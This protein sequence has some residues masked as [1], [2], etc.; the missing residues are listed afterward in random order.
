M[1]SEWII[2]MPLG[3]LILVGA[4][5][6]VPSPAMGQNADSVQLQGFSA[7]HPEARPLELIEVTLG[8]M[9]GWGGWPDRGLTRARRDVGCASRTVSRVG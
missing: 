2:R 3:V 4:M 7:L 6:T 8:V 1:R 5:A 9:G